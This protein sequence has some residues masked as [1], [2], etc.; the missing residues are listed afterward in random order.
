MYSSIIRLRGCRNRGQ[1]VSLVITEE[2]EEV[3][4]VELSREENEDNKAHRLV[5]SMGGDHVPSM[6]DDLFSFDAASAHN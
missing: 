2:V 3:R 5:A 1:N 6:E 4:V